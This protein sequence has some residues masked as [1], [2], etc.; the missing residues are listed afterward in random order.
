ME[1]RRISSLRDMCIRCAPSLLRETHL[2]AIPLRTSPNELRKKRVGP[3]P[4]KLSVC[5]PL[6]Y[7]VA[8]LSIRKPPPGCR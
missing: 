7:H 8:Y 5:E 3:H 2:I 4:Q 6:P 1:S